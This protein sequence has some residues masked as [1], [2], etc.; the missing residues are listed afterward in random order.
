[1]S[2]K[3][4]NGA[5]SL[6]VSGEGHGRMTRSSHGLPKVSLGPAMPYPSMPCRR[7]PPNGFMAVL[8][9]ATC[10][11]GG[12]RSSS[13]LLDAPCRT[14]LALRLIASGED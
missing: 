14:P 3:A 6:I 5:L 1:V 13:P 4:G 9:V 10:R 12:L 11:A 2:D 8:G 7:P